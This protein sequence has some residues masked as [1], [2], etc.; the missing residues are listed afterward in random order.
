VWRLRI[1]ALFRGSSIDRDNRDEMQAHLEYLS[2]D[3][4]AHGL[5]PAEARIKARRDFG[6][7]TQLEEASRDARGV[8]W[9]HDGIQ[10]GR[11][12]LRLLRRTPG[13]TL[14][15][16]LTLALG[17]GANTAIFS[18]VD[19]VLLRTLPV[20]Q[21]HEL[22][23][24]QT[25]GASG[26]EGVP[27]FPFFERVRD[28]SSSFAGLAAFAADELRVEVDGSVEQV[29]GQIASGSYFE[30][31]GLS[32]AIG[33]LFTVD[34]ERLDPP[35]TVIGYGYWQRRF[36][37]DPRAIGT[38]VTFGDRSYTIV[39]VTPPGFSGLT[40]GR[41]IEM[42]VP[43]TQARDMLANIDTWGWYNAV[44]RLK[45]ATS[46]Q[47]AAAEVDAALQAFMA[48][49]MQPAARRERF[50]RATLLSAAQGSDG[51]RQRFGKPLFALTAIAAVVLLIAWRPRRPVA[52]PGDD[53]NS[54]AV[55]A[56]WSDRSCGRVSCGS[57]ACGVLCCRP[58]SDCARPTLRLAVCGVCGRGRYDRRPR[59]RIVAGGPQRTH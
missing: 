59:D 49:T 56:R 37:G 41:Q 55:R 1:R 27:P 39:G 24:L 20:R 19:T 54:A 45:S 29:Y 4:I 7:L 16:V 25:T 47:T 40:P 51:L 5:A 17:I 14:A 13:F 31:L 9:L 33:R 48:E 35:V 22:V 3:Y 12:G 52:P 28:H 30:L 18:L 11:Y 23:F 26:R 57:N 36:G 58:Q 10:D 2:Q 34:D 42:T 8:R 32:P 38:P 50:S 15:A 53:R 43:I 21:P 44:G 46:V 6:G